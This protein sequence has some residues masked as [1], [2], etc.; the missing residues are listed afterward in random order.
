MQ[1]YQTAVARILLALV[2]LVPVIITINIMT[3]DPNGYM[4]YQKLLNSLGLLSF[5][6][7]LLIGT[8][9]FGGIALLLGFKT[10][11]V[12]LILMV[13]SIFLALVYIQINIDAFVLNMGIAAG[14]LILSIYPQTGF[15]LDNRKK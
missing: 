8:K 3:S 12:A 2:F 15:S 7:P 10:K 1:H 9:L 13:L 5:F 6:A 4:N 11:I 14:L